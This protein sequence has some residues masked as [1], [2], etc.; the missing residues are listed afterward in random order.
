M[1]SEVL[2]W[3]LKI[4]PNIT[5]IFEKLLF[6]GQKMTKSRFW[7]F[8]G[9]QLARRLL[10]KRG[11]FLDPLKSPIFKN[12]KNPYC[13][14]GGILPKKRSSRQKQL[15][16]AQNRQKGPFLDI[17]RPAHNKEKSTLLI[18]G[19]K[20]GSKKRPKKRSKMGQ[21]LVPYKITQKGGK[22]RCF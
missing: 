19:S 4:D 10:G 3:V 22:N 18:L 1:F 14:S 20:I 11:S 21:K 6:L 17:F 2:Y 16:F 9:P 8:F 15:N 12:P 7:P 5:P 13:G